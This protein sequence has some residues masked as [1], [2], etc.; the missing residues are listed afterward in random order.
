MVAGCRGI[1]IWPG[2]LCSVLSSGELE[3]RVDG[4]VKRLEWWTNNEKHHLPS[5]HRYIRLSVVPPSLNS[6]SLRKSLQDSL[7]SLFG[8]TSA[9][10]YVD[11]LWLA[12]DGSQL[13]LRVNE[14]SV[15]R[16]SINAAV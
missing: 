15:Q 3:I 13:I 14:Q 1:K 12:D 9:S 6:L 4:D 8:V 5:M 11:I 10:I 16:M 7:D 2:N